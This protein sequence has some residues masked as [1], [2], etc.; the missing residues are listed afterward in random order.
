MRHVRPIVL[1]AEEHGLPPEGEDLYPPC[2]LCELQPLPHGLSAQH[3]VKGRVFLEECCGVRGDG[4]TLGFV[5]RLAPHILHPP[6][7][8]GKWQVLGDGRWNKFCCCLRAHMIVCGAA[9]KT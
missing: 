2:T 7:S 1:E 8:T 9:G 3:L 5:R 6:R 4:S